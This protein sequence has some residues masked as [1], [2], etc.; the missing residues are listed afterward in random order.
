LR[1]RERALA[2]GHLP[3]DGAPLQSRVRARA[4]GA[5]ADGPERDP[6]RIPVPDASGL[7]EGA[8]AAAFDPD[9][10][11]ADAPPVDV[12]MLPWIPSGFRTLRR[13]WLTAEVLACSFLSDPATRAALPLN[14]SAKT[15]S[16]MAC[17][18]VV[19]T[20]RRS[21]TRG[22]VGFFSPCTTPYPRANVGTRGQI[23]RGGRWR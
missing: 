7:D 2:P 20:S 23:G 17:P 22:V 12:S 11:L 5:A 3:H 16:F 10:K 14:S 19:R 18:P 1:A 21:P 9:S 6:A 15:S 4:E 13:V 8:R